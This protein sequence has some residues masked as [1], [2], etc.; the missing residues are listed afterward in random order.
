MDPSHCDDFIRHRLARLHPGN[1]EDIAFELI[2][3]GPE[4]EL[5]ML[6]KS[7]LEALRKKHGA[8]PICSL[9]K[10]FR[11]L[12]GDFIRVVAGPGWYELAERRGSAWFISGKFLRT[13]FSF[14]DSEEFRKLP[15]QLICNREDMVN[16]EQALPRHGIVSSFEDATLPK[17]KS[18]YLFSSA[19]KFGFRPLLVVAC[20]FSFVM[21]NASAFALRESADEARAIYSE[22]LK[23]IKLV[24]SEVEKLDAETKKL[25]AQNG[26]ENE[27]EG[28]P[29][30]VFV[31]LARA[32]Q[33]FRLS[34]FGYD[35]GRFS[36]RGSA[37]GALAF[38]EALRSI[39]GFTDI[40]LS[41]VQI[42]DSGREEFS[43]SGEFH[44]R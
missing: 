12:P 29:G 5:L 43:L 44:D 31:S 4:V 20:V 8:L 1:P 23:E 27:W 13:G 39:P 14:L 7:Q 36:L 19:P 35:Y 41:G 10:G 33:A 28:N 40:K 32:G 9:V 3:K 21:L 26:S 2:G 42:L 17:K 15:L 16:A 25:Q 38:A 18:N 30:M 24:S 6:K 37:S 11:S 34:V 22:S